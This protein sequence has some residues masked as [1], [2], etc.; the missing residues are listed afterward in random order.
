MDFAPPTR[1]LLDAALEAGD[2]ATVGPDRL[3]TEL[4]LTLEEPDPAAVARRANAL[5]IAPH[6]FAPLQHAADCPQAARP[7]LPPLVRAGLLTYAL[8]PDEREA[9]IARYRLPNDAARVLR[10]VGR[11]REHSATL[12]QPNLRASEL[13]VLL[14]PFSSTAL[15]VVR[16]MHDGTI[17]AHIVRYVDELR[18]TA[19]LLD[20]HALRALGVAP[21]PRLGALL[22]EL[23]AARL[24]GLV[25]TRADEEAWVRQRLAEQAAAADVG[26][27]PNR[28]N[29]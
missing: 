22:A 15:D 18:P 3:R 23:R 19:P 2:L 17:A 27:P 7:N 9:L 1:A 24:D 26:A 25:Q 4:C 14:R 12:Q 10:E 11:L 29:T 21:G 20:G 8:T 5:G 28:T 13:D 6:L 16:Y